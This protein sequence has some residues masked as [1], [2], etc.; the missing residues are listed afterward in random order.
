MN[1]DLLGNDPSVIRPRWSLFQ[2]RLEL[3]FGFWYGPLNHSSSSSLKATG[4]E[5]ATWALRFCSETVFQSCMP[6]NSLSPP[7]NLSGETM[8]PVW[9]NGQLAQ[10]CGQLALRISKLFW[11]I[12]SS[13]DII[14][15]GAYLRRQLCQQ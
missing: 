11:T 10:S 6:F 7:F 9:E 1:T 4:N 8:S 13:E 15:E 2:A 3:E 14:K 12:V 5:H